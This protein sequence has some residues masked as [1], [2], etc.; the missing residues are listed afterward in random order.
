[1]EL[2][3][4]D[5]DALNSRNSL[6]RPENCSIQLRHGLLIEMGVPIFR[7]FRGALDI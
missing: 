5:I 6:K 4:H 3:A 1:M 7:G 2:P